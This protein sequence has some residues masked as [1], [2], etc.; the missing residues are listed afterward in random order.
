MHNIDLSHLQ[1]LQ[2]NAKRGYKSRKK[3][4]YRRPLRVAALF[5]PGSGHLPVKEMREM[6]QYR[7]QEPITD[8]DGQTECRT[9]CS[10]AETDPVL[11]EEMSQEEGEMTAAP[12]TSQEGHVEEN[13]GQ[14]IFPR[15]VK[16]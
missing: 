5:Y 9:A 10:G 2:H 12:I 14:L 3:R 7:I 6:Y 8:E 11:P 16:M 15:F 13:A 4:N 1:I